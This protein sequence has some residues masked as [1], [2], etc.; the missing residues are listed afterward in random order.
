MLDKV[1][2]LIAVQSDPEGYVRRLAFQDEMDKLAGGRLDA[3]KGL[4]PRMS[5]SI[6]QLPKKRYVR[7]GLEPM[8]RKHTWTS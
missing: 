5:A 8:H 3:L 1:A 7:A 2:G 6:K 4:T